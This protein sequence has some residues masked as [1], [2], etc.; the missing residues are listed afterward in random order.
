MSNPLSIVAVERDTGLSKDT[1]RM[2]ERRYGFPSPAR[3]AFGERCYPPEQI[4]KLRIVKRLLDAGQ[5]PRR[6]MAMPLAELQLLAQALPA[7]QPVEIHEHGTLQDQFRLIRSHD[8]AALRGALRQQLSHLGVADFIGEV[9]GPLITAVGDGWLRGHLQVFEEHLFT[10]VMQGVLRQAIAAIPEAP[11][12]D[13]RP[14]VLLATLSGEPHGLGLLMAEALLGLEGCACT[15]L[16]T[17]AP[18]WHVSLAAQAL[19]ADI[20]ALSFSG[21]I[22]PNQ[23]VQDL[24]ELRTRLGPAVALWAGGSAPVLQRRQVPGV[25][26]LATFAAAAAELRRWRDENES[27]QAADDVPKMQA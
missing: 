16:G 24:T 19:D 27:P 11:R 23:V 22:A 9:A 7:R 14:C 25:R 6:L 10:E 17:Q 3:D 12:A 18:I 8:V 21:C 15:S 20:V 4:D 5:R 1:L 13:A 2:W 26:P